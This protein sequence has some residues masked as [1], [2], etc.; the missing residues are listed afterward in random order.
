MIR[1]PRNGFL[2]YGIVNALEQL[3]GKVLA[4][5]ELG[6]VFDE[7]VAGH[8]PLQILPVQVGVQQH[9]GARQ[10]VNGVERS[11]PRPLSTN[12]IRVTF[13]VPEGIFL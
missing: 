6:Q 2:L 3:F 9:D 5:V 11:E 13:D 8:L 7:L 12:H 4:V 1:S 10:R